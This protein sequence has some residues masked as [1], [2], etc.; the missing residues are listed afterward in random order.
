MSRTVVLIGANRGIGLN[1]ARALVAQ[2]WN[3]VASVR[4]QT[5]SLRD[6]SVQEIQSVASRILEI[7]LSNEQTVVEAA[8]CFGDGPLDM[9]VNIAG[10]GPE[11]DNW[12][13]HTAEI[14]KEKF[15]INTVGPFLT[16][17]HFH[18]N[19]KKRGGIIV[20]I[21]SNL[22]SISMCNGE[23]LAYRVSKAALNMVTVTLAKEFQANGD[24]IVVI[25]LNPGY[26]ATRITNLR[27]RDDMDECIAGIVKV[28]D[29]V[30]MDQTGTFLD[31]RGETLPW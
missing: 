9:L 17:K 19:L 12:Y 14:L 4:P 1:L 20:N 26:V 22:G 10:V 6:P 23:D 11:P 18:K 30:G 31:W 5:K 16:S 3:V 29:S 2:G 13:D 21:S 24:N 25:A 15:A 27:F 28:L 7:D 8:K